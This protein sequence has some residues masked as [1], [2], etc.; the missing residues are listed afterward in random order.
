MTHNNRVSILNVVL[1]FVAL[2]LAFTYGCALGTATMQSRLDAC[3][4]GFYD[5]MGAL[6]YCL[7]TWPCPT[8]QEP[9][10]EDMPCWDCATMGNRI[11]GPVPTLR[12]P[13]EPPTPSA[14]NPMWSI[15]DGAY[16][17]PSGG[18]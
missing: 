1:F 9:C 13:G 11:C 2:A 10:R 8:C 17:T 7:Q 3:G 15:P 16:P 5:T 4:Q 6:D 18:R 14:D 12:V